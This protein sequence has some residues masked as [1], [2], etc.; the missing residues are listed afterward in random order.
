MSLGVISSS[1]STENFSTANDPIADPYTTARRRFAS[2][3]SPVSREIAHEAAGERIAG[4]GRIEHRLERI[5]R[6]EEDRR[7]A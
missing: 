3:M 7:F 5:G 6:R 4:A 1:R 2:E